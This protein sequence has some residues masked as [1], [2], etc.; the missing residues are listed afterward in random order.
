VVVAL[1][2]SAANL[3]SLE[4][5]FAHFEPAATEGLAVSAAGAHA[6]AEQLRRL[7]R[8]Q[9]ARFPL[10]LSRAAIL[11]AGLLCLGAALAA[12]G[13]ARARASGRGL[14]YGL[15]GKVLRGAWLR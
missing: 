4:A 11:P 14:R 12:S 8:E 2:G 9:R 1:G 7:T 13:A 10:E 3:A 15:A 6:W 5:E